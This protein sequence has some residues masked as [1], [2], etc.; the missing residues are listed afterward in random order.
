MRIKEVKYHIVSYLT[1]GIPMK[2]YFLLLSLFTFSLSAGHAEAACELPAVG[3]LADGEWVCFT[4]SKP[5]TTGALCEPG[6]SECLFEGGWIE[7]F[8]LKGN[9]FIQHTPSYVSLNDMIISGR[10]I[11]LTGVPSYNEAPLSDEGLFVK[12]NSSREEFIE[13]LK[14]SGL[15][16]R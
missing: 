4:I 13:R 9:N 6:E 5:T 3:Y 11:L 15:Y 10:S 12:V 8:P 1:K 14:R 2:K 7:T 16:P